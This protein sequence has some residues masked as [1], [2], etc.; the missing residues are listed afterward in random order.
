M[1][2]PLNVLF[3][4]ADQWRGECLSALGHPMVRT[5]NLDALAAEGVLFERH[6]ANTAPCGPSRASLHTGLYL[7][8]HRSGDQR[9]AARCAPYQLGAGGREARLRSGA[10]RLHRHQPRSARRAGRFS[11]GCAPTRVRCRACGRSC[12]WTASRSPGPTGWRAQGYAVPETPQQAYGWRAP[13]PD[14]EDGAAEP[15]PLAF[16]AEVDDVAFLTGQLIDYLRA[17]RTAVHRPPV[18]AAP[19]PAV[20]GAAALQRHVRPGGRS[21]LQPRHQP[22]RGSDAASVAGL[23]AEAPRF[24]ARRRTRSG[25]GG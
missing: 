13:G 10:L 20:R 4:T 24:R 1:P 15:R 21:R 9:H 8:N 25:C 18:A 6:Y 5:P 2:A 23:A 11:P 17:R 16:P 19:A 3:I 7:Q 14:W 12:T 22:R